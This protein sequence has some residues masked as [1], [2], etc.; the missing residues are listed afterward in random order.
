[1]YVSVYVIASR[2]HLLSA[3]LGIAGQTGPGTPIPRSRLLLCFSLLVLPS[4]RGD[5]F[6]GEREGEEHRRTAE[7]VTAR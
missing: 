6:A 1:V 7:K 3:V 4:F 5:W 2:K